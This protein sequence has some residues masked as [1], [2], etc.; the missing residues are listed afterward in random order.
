MI[1]I[2]KYTN[3][4]FSSNT[5]LLWKN[6]EKDCLIVDCGDTKKLL[7]DIQQ[8][9]LNPVAILL[10]HAHFDHIYGLNDFLNIFSMTKI[11]TTDFGYDALLSQKLNLSKYHEIPFELFLP[12]AIRVIEKDCKLLS[13]SYIDI[14]IFHVPGHNPSCLAYRI[15][16][17]LFTGDAFIPGLNVVTNVP[18][19][20]KQLAFDNYK[21][22]SILSDGLIVCPGHGNIL[23]L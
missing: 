13:I 16:N 12:S 1:R 23:G 6:G 17:F 4:I 3:K 21:K 18:K 5:F 14:E 2:K 8:F 10:S 19:A 22:L 11:Y 15:D 9:G 20:N 7:E